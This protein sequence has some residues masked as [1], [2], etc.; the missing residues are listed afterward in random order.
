[1]QNGR[2]KNYAITLTEN[3]TIADLKQLLY[4]LTKVQPKMQKL[5]AIKPKSKGTKIDEESKLCDLKWKKNNTF[6]MVGNPEEDMFVDPESPSDVLDDLDYDYRPDD[7]EVATDDEN[8]KKLQKA[9]ESTKI[10]YIN[11]PR[12]GKS[13]LVLDIDYTIFDMK[14]AADN[15]D[16]LKRPF[17]D[18]L[19]QTLYPH[20][21]ICFWSQTSWKWIE[22]KLTELG[23]LSNPNYKVLFAL[24]KKAMFTVSSKDRHGKMYKHQVKALQL[25]WD[26]LPKMYS[27]K[28]TI[29]IDDLG[30]NFAMNPASG[31]K[32]KAYKNAHKNIK[33][34]QELAFLTRYLLLIKDMDMSKLNHSNWKEYLKENAHKLI[35]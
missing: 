29:H 18:F 23:I 34:D 9:I 20:Y 32:I 14:S 6:M 25:I 26:K 2:E 3:N 8:M 24:D 13:L 31:L 5:V 21:D 4:S 1:M 12:Q 30:R 35:M 22:I 17:T 15:F 16:Q 11:Q 33:T 10:N 19:L 27:H 28:N 7:D